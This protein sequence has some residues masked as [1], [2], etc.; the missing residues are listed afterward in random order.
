MLLIELVGKYDFNVASFRDFGCSHSSWC[1]PCEGLNTA[2]ALNF[3]V[4]KC[5]LG[6]FESLK[7]W[8]LIKW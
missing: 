3:A 4:E 8:T 2:F 7:P 5:Y 1:S 6:A